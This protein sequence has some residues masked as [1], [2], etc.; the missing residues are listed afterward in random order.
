M[1]AGTYPSSW[2]LLAPSTIQEQAIKALLLLHQTFIL[3]ASEQLKANSV[4][5]KAA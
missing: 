4:N 2:F 5:L 1:A 3:S